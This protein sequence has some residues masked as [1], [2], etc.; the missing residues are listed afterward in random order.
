VLCSIF[1]QVCNASDKYADK[2]SLEM[3][4]FRINDKSIKDLPLTSELEIKQPAEA[5][6]PFVIDQGLKP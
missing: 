1:E 2:I 4:E 5:G 6:C 3:F